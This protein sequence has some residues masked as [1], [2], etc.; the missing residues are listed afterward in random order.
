MARSPRA[1]RFR[2]GRTPF[3]SAQARRLVVD[4][5]KVHTSDDLSDLSDLV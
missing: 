5:G 3:A 4:L 2:R 1:G